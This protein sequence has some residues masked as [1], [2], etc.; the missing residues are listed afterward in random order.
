MHLRIIHW[1]SRSDLLFYCC[2]ATHIHVCHTPR[3]FIESPDRNTWRSSLWL[4]NF[5]ILLI[6]QI[7]INSVVPCG[8]SIL[9]ILRKKKRKKYVPFE[10]R[11]RK[12]W[13]QTVPHLC[14]SL[15]VQCHQI[16]GVIFEF[17]KFCQYFLSVHPLFLKIF[18]LRSL[19]DLKKINIA[20]PLVQTLMF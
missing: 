6:W 3:G 1:S 8:S 7:L 14:W 16:L 12:I 10:R 11:R 4:I 18:L 2:N 19:W 13:K 9:L 5:Y 15:M 20:T 17:I